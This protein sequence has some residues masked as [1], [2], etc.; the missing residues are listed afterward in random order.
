MIYKHS[1]KESRAHASLYALGALRG[2]EGREFEQHLATGCTV[3]AVAVE[4]FAPIVAE[5][6]YAAPL[7][8]PRPEIR[9]RVLARVA[10]ESLLKDHPVLDKDGSR[11]VR[12][13][14]IAWQEGNAPAVEIKTL[15]VDAQRGYNTFLVRMT[16]GAVLRPHRPEFA[17]PRAARG[18]DL[19]A[20]QRPGELRGDL[21]AR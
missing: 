6:G 1:A 9:A 2:D 14:R 18:A 15:F 20:S 11:F 21:P 17:S 13:T 8:A 5:L 7:Q 4:A 12:V 10:A 16:P 19:Q 3:C